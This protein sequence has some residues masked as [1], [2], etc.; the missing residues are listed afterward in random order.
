MAHKHSS[1][2]KYFLPVFCIP[3]LLVGL[4]LIWN[5]AWYTRQQSITLRR[6]TL[7]QVAE[8]VDALTEQCITLA[9]QAS[10]SEPLMQTLAVEE[11]DEAFITQWLSVHQ[12]MMGQPITLALYQRGSQDIF[13]AEGKTTYRAFEDTVNDLAASLAGLYTSLN[14]D[15]HPTSCTLYQAA[16]DPYSIGY[17]FP[18]TDSRAHTPASLCVLIPSATLQDLFSR[19][20]DES[21]ASL[22]ILNST[23]QPLL[24]PLRHNIDLK[25]LRTHRGAEVFTLPESGL[26]ALRHVSAKTQQVYCVAMESQHFYQ[27]NESLLMLYPLIAIL[28]LIGGLLAVALAKGTHRRLQAARDQNDALVGKLDAQAETIRTLVLRKLIDG[29]RKD[30][31]AIEY[32]LRCANITLDKPHFQV[33]I[34][35]FPTE[36]D[37]EQA[38]P[39]CRSLCDGAATDSAVFL[40]FAR[41]EQRQIIVLMNTAG[42]IPDA[43]LSLLRRIRVQL[44]AGQAEAG[45]GRIRHNILRLNNSYVEASVALQEKLNHA[46]QHLYI[47]APPASEVS[48]ARALSM[49]KSLVRECLRNGNQQLLASTIRRMFEKIVCASENEDIRRLACFDVINLCVS[50]A[51]EFDFPLAEDTVSGMCSCQTTD[52][53]HSLISDAL[54]HLCEQ[55]GAQATEALTTSKYNLMGFVQEHFRDPDLSL[56]MI[57]DQLNLSQS[58]IS[59]LFKD[60]TGQ[61]FISYVKQLRFNYVRKQLTETERPVKDIVIETGYTDVASFSRSF[62]AEEGVTPGEYRRLRQIGRTAESHSN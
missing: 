20:F 21:T 5:D 35:L 15:Q 29:S 11:P 44:P 34:L 3:V 1:T 26:T 22:T 19:F 61:T 9:R 60:E 48:S 52:A 7:E 58:Y 18:L 14:R 2:L 38:E 55:V 8:S 32:N 6:A 12:K 25:A 50:L 45:V 33:A 46:D 40:S 56:T 51:D 57:S 10:A 62:K 39:L 4:L 27:Q 23:H 31:R 43:L 59:K 17:V 28:V 42:T 30:A 37:T 47:Y 13:L 36:Q 16:A 41:A 49:E 53:L 24:L 54:L